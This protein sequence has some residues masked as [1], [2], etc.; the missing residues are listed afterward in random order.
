[1]ADNLEE[2][3]KMVVDAAIQDPTVPKFYM[4]GF[5]IGR[6]ASDIFLVM[7]L[8]THTLGIVHMSFTTAK[9]LM[10]ALEEA[11]KALEAKIEHPILS[12]DE[13]RD[14]DEQETDEN[15]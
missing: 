15:I 8:M 13:L 6:S 10:I 7:N 5:N 1:M 11:M 4:N 3:S 14:T 12:M 2:Q 9:T